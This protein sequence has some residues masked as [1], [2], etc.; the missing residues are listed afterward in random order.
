MD[1]VLALA[2]PG[3]PL[4]LAAGLFLPRFGETA[5]R[6][7]PWVP[8]L[9]LVALP[10]LHGKV[11]ELPWLLLGTRMGIDGLAAPL[12]L[13]A[14]VAWTLAG[15]HA[16]YYLPAEGQAR[17]FFFWLLTWA[18]N[19]GVFLMLD[20][21]SFYSA[22]AM[23]TF[24]A[25]GLVVFHG[26]PEDFRAGRVYIMMA[27]VGEA[28]IIGALLTLGGGFGNVA[29]E[30]GAAPVAQLPQAHWVAWLFLAGFA[31]KMGIVPLHMWLPLAHPQAPVPASAVLSGVILKA[32]LMGWVRFLPFGADGFEA[33]GMTLAV[34]GL[35][36]AFYGAAVGLTQTRA[37]TVLAYSSISQMG[38]I[39]TA[40][41]LALAFPS[42][43]AVLL[44]SAI[45]FALHHGLAKAALFLSVDTARSRPSMARALMWIPALALAGAPLTSG[46]LAKVLLKSS[47][48]EAVPWLD[49]A[50]LASSLATTLMMARF[51]AL[52]WPRS[53][54]PKPGNPLP[55]I[56]LIVAGAAVPWLVTPGFV[57]GALSLPF[58]PDY[59]ED[60]LVPVLAGIALAAVALR[61]WPRALRPTLPEGDLIAVFTYWPRM[62]WPRAQPPGER[63]GIRF[64]WPDGWLTVG[65]GAL[66]ALGPA[67]F[68][69]L[70]ALALLFLLAG[71]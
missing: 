31:V 13:L 4:L 61:W 42:A 34:A 27:I 5:L 43:A 26:R 53:S 69:A 44:S 40:V 52:A 63:H 21:A 38:L 50:L 25:Y 23:M 16:R 51:L 18:G 7:A 39:G 9:A 71:P 48:P 1:T 70:T 60:T 10:V 35:I 11:V 68:I 17:F 32:G 41:G 45:L 22:Y 36:T 15:W 47:V 3:L 24:A 59:L 19:A 54:E 46:A 14:V 64:R 65:E 29:L 8:L 37:K 6:L 57:P 28:M 55:W 12:L 20:A 30:D 49:H 56:G 67:L 66:T 62:G 2:L 33:A 58:R